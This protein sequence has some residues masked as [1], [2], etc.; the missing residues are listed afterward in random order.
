MLYVN[1]MSIKQ[2]NRCFAMHLAIY[3]YIFDTFQ[4]EL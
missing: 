4:N 2:V 1:Y 3:Q